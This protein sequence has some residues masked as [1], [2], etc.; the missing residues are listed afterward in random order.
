MKADLYKLT[1]LSDD[2]PSWNSQMEAW[3]Q[4]GGAL[5]W[6]RFGGVGLEEL[7][8]GA[9]DTQEFVRCASAIPGWNPMFHE[10]CIEDGILPEEANAVQLQEI[11]TAEEPGV[12][13][14]FKPKEK[15]PRLC[16]MDCGREVH[17]AL[18]RYWQADYIPVPKYALNHLFNSLNEAV[19]FAR[20]KGPNNWLVWRAALE[21]AVRSL[22][23]VDDT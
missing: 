14:N 12:T 5:L 7:V 4:N 8:L 2:N 20:G 3:W 10:R 16:C 9:E 15:V 19:A 1:A 13:T 11:I 17:A 6:N 23:N 22:T 18:Q 21:D